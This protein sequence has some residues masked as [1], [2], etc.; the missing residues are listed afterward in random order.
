MPIDFIYKKYGFD[1]VMP[2]S[3]IN[4][5]RYNGHLYSVPVNIH[6]ANV[7][8]YNPKSLKTAGITRCR[9]TWAQFI[10]ALEKAKAPA[11]SRSRWASSGRRSTCWRR[12]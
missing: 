11:S 3:L 9:K 1:K 10:A 4:Q 8:W 12:S 2:K 7:L 6:R 5:I